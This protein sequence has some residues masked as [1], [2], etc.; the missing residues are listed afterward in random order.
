[1]AT[2]FLSLKALA[3]ASSGTIALSAIGPEGLLRYQSRQGGAFFTG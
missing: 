2:N 3:M 1:M